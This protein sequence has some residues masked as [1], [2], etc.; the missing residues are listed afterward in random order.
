MDARKLSC[1]L[2]TITLLPWAT[3]AQEDDSLDMDEL[4]ADDFES[5]QR[6]TINDPLEGINRAIFS[7]ND[8]FYTHIAKP[9]AKGYRAVVPTPV[10]KSIGN[11]FDNLKFPSRFVSCALQG[12]V[13]RAGQETGAFIV[14]TTV[15]VAGIFKPSENLY[16]EPAPSEDI[17]QAFGHWGIGH[18]FYFVMPFL[19]PTSARDF[20]GNVADRIVEPIPEPWS[21]L[22]DD[23]TR[24]ILSVVENVNELPTVMELYDSMS[25]SS[26]DKYSAVRDAYAQRRA[27]QVAE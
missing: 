21:Q 19:G 7:F 13:R 25:R 18:G 6:V 1:I 15:G 11:V 8:G 14:N 4:F 9:L 16:D 2:F 20:T 10:E 12:K 22:D 23:D 3:H 17:G 5:E 26:I 27:S 24:L